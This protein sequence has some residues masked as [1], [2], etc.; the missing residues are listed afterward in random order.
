MRA[1]ALLLPLVVLPYADAA[2]L[3]TLSQ[4]HD[5]YRSQPITA[6]YSAAKQTQDPIY[7]A[8]ELIKLVPSAEVGKHYEVSIMVRELPMRPMF[9]PDVIDI[10]NPQ[11]QPQ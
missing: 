8:Q 9:D 5:S 10:D 1:Q 2:E 3:I 4:D 6:L 7:T 11:R